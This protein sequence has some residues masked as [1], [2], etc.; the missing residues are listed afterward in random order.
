MRRGEMGVGFRLMRLKRSGMVMTLSPLDEIVIRFTT[1]FGKRDGLSHS[2]T[3]SSTISNGILVLLLI[4]PL[5]PLS[6]SY[7][8]VVS[9]PREKRERIAR[10]L[11]L[12]HGL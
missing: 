12:S 7:P 10:Y 4:Y 6:L 3:I 11:H 9:D 1:R 8:F 2:H 5:V